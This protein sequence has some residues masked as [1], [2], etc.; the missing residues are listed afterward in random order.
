M[1]TG[2]QG[3]LLF[4]KTKQE[5][6]VHT[7]LGSKIGWRDISRLN[8]CKFSPHDLWFSWQSLSSRA[9][10]G[11]PR[12]PDTGVENA[13]VGTTLCVPFL[14]CVCVCS[15]ACVCVRVHGGHRSNLDAVPLALSTYFFFF[16]RQG[17]SLAWSLWSSFRLAGLCFPSA[18]FTSL[19]HRAQLLSM[20]SGS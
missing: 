11:E 19:S 20:G 6:D 12:P 3:K 2:R 4:Y 18:R 14:V 13:G 10:G 15:H 5:G 9:N 7:D 1:V 16:L 8:R 17:V